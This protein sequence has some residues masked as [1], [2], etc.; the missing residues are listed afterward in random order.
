MTIAALALALATP[1]DPGAIQ[2]RVVNTGFEALA[3]SPDGS[4]LFMGGRDGMVRT[5][6]L[7]TMSP[8]R[9]YR[10]PGT[11]HPQDDNTIYFIAVSPDGRRIAVS[12]DSHPVGDSIDVFDVESG[13]VRHTVKAYRQRPGL[14]N[15]A[16]FYQLLE[17]E[18]RTTIYPIMRW[19]IGEGAPNLFRGFSIS[20]D[21][22]KADIDLVKSFWCVGDALVTH[23]GGGIRIYPFSKPTES[24][25][26]LFEKPFAISYNNPIDIDSSGR[27]CTVDEQGRL[28]FSEGITKPLRMVGET[29]DMMGKTGYPSRCRF[30]GADRVI[31]LGIGG[32]QS[33]RGLEVVP[34]DLM[35]WSIETGK[36][37]LR[38]PQPAG[39]I[40]DIVYSPRGYVA[41]SR[42]FASAKS[43][44][45]VLYSA[46]DG[47]P[48]F[49]ITSPH[50]SG[51]SATVNIKK[52]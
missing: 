44:A 13:Q 31:T 46:E 39:L 14:S 23:S 11:Y 37:E 30:A 45:V 35:L 10:R 52:L 47:T 27:M 49:E 19:R 12:K 24:T 15:D 28:F 17:A 8:G 33:S 20:E 43:Q 26:Q 9:S 5:V 41:L 2:D 16:L 29:I 7:E 3:I 4:T 22:Q 51:P 18:S 48:R 34:G 42:Y 36:V 38:I 21:G 32:R 50:T 40:G 1:V 25:G 6:N